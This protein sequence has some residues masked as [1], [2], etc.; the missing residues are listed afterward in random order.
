LD[1]VEKR[2]VEASRDALRRDGYSEVEF[3]WLRKQ[4]LLMQRI[5]SAHQAIPAPADA[6]SA[7]KQIR[8]QF[9]DDVDVIARL[10]KAFVDEVRSKVGV[11]SLCSTLDSFLLWAHYASS[12]KGFAVEFDQFRLAHTF[13][14][15]ATGVFFQ[16]MPVRYSKHPETV[17]FF[18][19]TT[20]AMFFSKIQEWSYESEYRVILPLE[21]CDKVKINLSKKTMFLKKIKPENVTG[22]VFGWKTPNEDIDEVRKAVQS[23]GSTITM[24]RAHVVD[25]A[26]RIVDL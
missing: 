26:I 4:G 12:A 21:E 13:P 18:P 1:F 2:K 5:K 24:R 19:S 6:D 11:L 22:I 9:Y 23:M 3:N 14:G 15:D 16:L 10:Q 25:A 8:K 17:T 20:L 7:L